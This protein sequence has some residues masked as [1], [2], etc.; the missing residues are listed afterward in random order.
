MSVNSHNYLQDAQRYSVQ[1]HKKR[2]KQQS[3]TMLIQEQATQISK[4]MNL[5]KQINNKLMDHQTFWIWINLK[6]VQPKKIQQQK[7][8]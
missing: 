6:I 7:L 5:N 2:K 3:L 4:I 8:K 1:K